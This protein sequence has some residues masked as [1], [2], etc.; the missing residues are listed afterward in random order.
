MSVAHRLSVSFVRLLRQGRHM[1]S[2]A[3]AAPS[4]EKELYDLVIAG[5]GVVG[6][7][8]AC[9]LGECSQSWRVHLCMHVEDLLYYP[10]IGFAIYCVQ[11]SPRKCLHYLRC[12]Y[13][14]THAH[15][16]WYTYVHHAWHAHAHA[17]TLQAVSPLCRIR[18]SCCC[19]PH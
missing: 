8:L 1:C 15:T 10:C 9:S 17:P 6:A 13:A 3:T 11:F 4:D 19:S 2:S 12:S 16:S 5:G 7:A 14:H 18:R